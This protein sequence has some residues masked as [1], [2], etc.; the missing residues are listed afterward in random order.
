MLFMGYAALL[1]LMLSSIFLVYTGASI[2]RTFFI[3]AAAF[4]AL[5]CTATRRSATSRRWARS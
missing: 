3:S 5:A 4:G 1:G 2:T